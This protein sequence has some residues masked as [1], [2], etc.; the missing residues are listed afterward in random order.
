[1]DVI[2]RMPRVSWQEGT[3]PI[4]IILERESDLRDIFGYTTTNV[5]IVIVSCHM[6]TNMNKGQFPDDAYPIN[7]QVLVTVMIDK[8]VLV[9][10]HT[11][12]CVH[13]TRDVEGESAESF[14]P[15]GAG[16]WAHNDFLK[17][18]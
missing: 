13:T 8:G 7:N 10:K 1:M 16:I 18:L 11:T 9:H 14:Y 2:K 3:N 12:I 6:Y 5:H 4:D 17:G 15:T